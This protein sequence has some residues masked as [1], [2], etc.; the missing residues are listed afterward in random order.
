MMHKYI[1]VGIGNYVVF[2]TQQMNSPR[3]MKITPFKGFIKCHLMVP[4]L[5]LALESTLFLKS[6]IM[7]LSTCNK[8]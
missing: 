2:N 7:Y 4:I 1:D 8:T 6:S 3:K 5:N